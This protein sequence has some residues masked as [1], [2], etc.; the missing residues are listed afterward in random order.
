MYH[1]LCNDPEG[2]CKFARHVSLDDEPYVQCELR[3]ECD[4]RFCPIIFGEAVD[5]NAIECQ[6]E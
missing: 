2:D 4:Y 5:E 3:K 1:L 6:P